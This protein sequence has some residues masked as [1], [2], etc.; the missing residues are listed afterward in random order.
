MLTEENNQSTERCDE[1]ECQIISNFIGW[2]SE[3]VHLTK[4]GLHV[5]KGEKR[6]LSFLFLVVT[7]HVTI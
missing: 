4:G 3:E 7:S 5:Q 6:N 1:G 2:S